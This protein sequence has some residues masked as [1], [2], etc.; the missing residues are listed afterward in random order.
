MITLAEFIRWRDLIF[1]RNRRASDLAPTDM[2]E[3]MATE[4]LLAAPGLWP[5]F[6]EMGM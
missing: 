1:R 6:R 2:L 3:A 4:R 5:Q